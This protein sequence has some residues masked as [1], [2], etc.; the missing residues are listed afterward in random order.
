LC[1][2]PNKDGSGTISGVVNRYYAA[3]SSGATVLAGQANTLIPVDTTARGVT[4][5]IGKGD[6]LLIIQMQDADINSSN[7]DSYG[8]GIVGGGNNS[9]TLVA[10]VTTGASGSSDLRNVGRY[11]YVVADG[12]LTG[13][14]IPVR[15]AGAN[16]GLLYTYTSADAN[17]TQG[18]RR[19]QVVR[20]P[21]YKDVTLSGLTASS[22][23]GQAGG[24]VAIDVAGTLTLGNINVTS[25]GF[26]GGAGRG[27]TSGTAGLTY[28]DYRTL[29]TENPNGSKGEGI[30]GTPK[31]VYELTNTTSAI[32]NANEGYPNGS[33]GRG[34]PGNAGGGGT[35]GN[36]TGSNDEN[37]GG[38]GGG[39]GGNGGIGG[40]T[41]NSQRYTGGFGGVFNPTFDRLVLGGGGGA[42]SR[43][44]G[45]GLASSGGTGGGIVMIRAN[46]LAGAGTI[47]ADGSTG[48]TPVNDGGGGGGAGG[49]ILVVSAKGGGSITVNARGGRGT[50]AHNP[51]VPHGPGGGGGGG[52]LAF[53]SNISASADLSGGSNGLTDIDNNATTNNSFA[54]GATAGQNGQQTTLTLSQIPGALSGA[55]CP[56]NL[57]LVKR[58]TQIKTGN[59]TTNFTTFVNDTDTRIVSGNG[60]QDSPQ[61]QVGEIDNLPYWS[62][63]F[64]LGGGVEL[65][66]KPDDPVDNVAVLSNSE[67][68]YTI[69]FLSDGFKDAS[70][71][72]LCDS[73]D[74]NSIFIFN[75][76]NNVSPGTGVTAAARG[77][78]VSYNGQLLSYSGESDGDI[79]RFYAPGETLPDGCKQSSNPNGTLVVNLGVGATNT[80]GGIVLRATGTGMP[81]TSYG[82]VRFRV[83]VK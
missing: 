74:K 34:A 27:V 71:S 20:I 32:T 68:E 69:Y 6:L 29:S 16:N 28:T 2:T 39:N 77:V 7:S 58:I 14:S 30:A 40:Q 9:N 70:K 25:Q 11:E 18:Q 22:W 75:G 81:V 72:I 26:R 37:A 49:S 10:P 76:Y 15:G 48:V 46:L 59:Q 5:P 42:G 54:F 36:P 35:D 52:F 43:N 78:V 55:Q 50:D 33:F 31:Y 47:V 24:I 60:S 23:D 67:I 80:S 38:G 44:N 65:V 19:Y 41:W 45:S 83:R 73:L 8:D 21:Q 82:F 57:R 17:S 51:G 56:P 64:L 62:P 79:A 63:N 61:K 53:S 3:P 12:A 4:T 66:N 13:S 1:A